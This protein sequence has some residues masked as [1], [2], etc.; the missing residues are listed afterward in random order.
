MH[1]GW[2]VG[3]AELAVMNSHWSV[4]CVVQPYFFAHSHLH[5]RKIDAL[6]AAGFRAR[7]VSFVPERLFSKH[8]DRYRAAQ[9][10]GYM[11]IVRVRS[12][13]AVNRALF[14]FF[15]WRLLTGRRV[16]A[17]VLRCDPTPLLRL[18]KVWL[19]GRRLR[20]VLEHEGDQSAEYV[21]DRTFS[22]D[23]L[24]AE[25]P[26]AELRATYQA[27]FNEQAAQVTQADGLVLMSDEHVSL[28]ENRLGHTVRA[29][30]VP[31]LFDPATPGFMPEARTQ[32]RAEL[33]IADKAVLVYAG[34]VVCK[35]QRFETMCRFVAR[36]QRQRESVWFLGLVRMD[37]LGLA[38]DIVAR[39]GIAAIST[40][41]SVPS[42]EVMR[43][44]SA[45]DVALF[46]RHE[47]SMNTIVTS[48]KL[49]EYLAAG[50][51]VISTGAN[52]N[53]LNRFM[54]EQGVGLF[55]PD[56]LELPADFAEQFAHLL[57]RAGH[58]HWRQAVSAATLRRFSGAGD[59]LKKYCEFI[60]ELA[61]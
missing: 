24:P 7:G 59:P 11:E 9:K 4:F 39:S 43:Y 32:V 28:W 16:V 30:V 56:T 40:I 26:P 1:P 13:A 29:V 51:P 45:A 35:W 33:G 61:A 48:A 37:D 14:I 41:V 50:L 44:L 2:W 52:A 18:R 46:L 10:S 55:V 34:N 12:E 47:H 49:G 42:M 21:Y 60:R 5:R 20:I 25:E 22:E 8:V 57:T 23:S 38:N 17:H 27:M 6:R 3:L 19:L 54:R 31:T 15:A 53:V 58:A 36:L